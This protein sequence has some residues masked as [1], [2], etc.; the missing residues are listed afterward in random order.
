LVGEAQVGPLIQEFEL[1][2]TDAFNLQDYVSQ[3]GQGV[4][5]DRDQEQLGR[6]DAG[7]VLLRKV[8]ERELRALAEGRP[9]ARWNAERVGLEE[10]GANSEHG[11]GLSKVRAGGWFKQN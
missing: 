3:V 11:S 4:L 1:N 2:T 8:W 7:I 9:L 10:R 5:A 6:T